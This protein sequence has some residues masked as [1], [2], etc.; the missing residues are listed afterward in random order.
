MGAPPAEAGAVPA[1]SHLRPPPPTLSSGHIAGYYRRGEW[2]PIPPPPWNFHVL[3][4]SGFSTMCIFRG[5][6]NL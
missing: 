3:S 2:P 6:F 4:D 5:V 1:G